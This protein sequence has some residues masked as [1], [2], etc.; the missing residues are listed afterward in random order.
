VSREKLLGRQLI[1]EA[2]GRHAGRTINKWAQKEAGII[3]N[4]E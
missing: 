1:L 2:L 4:A 3:E